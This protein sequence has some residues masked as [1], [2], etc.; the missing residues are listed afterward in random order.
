MWGYE[1]LTNDIVGN[2]CRRCGRIFSND[3]S[4]CDKGGIKILSSSSSVDLEGL[5]VKR[6][7]E[8]EKKQQEIRALAGRNATERALNGGE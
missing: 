1:A 3:E 8:T 6:F 4:H 7:E 5:G 2:I